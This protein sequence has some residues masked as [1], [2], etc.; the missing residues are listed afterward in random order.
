MLRNE[1]NQVYA[2]VRC[3]PEQARLLRPRPLLTVEPAPVELVATGIADALQAAAETVRRES[4]AM[5]MGVISNAP[6]TDGGAR[7]LQS[8]GVICND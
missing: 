3:T 7:E 4:F 8:G 6:E 1:I 2:V 5:A